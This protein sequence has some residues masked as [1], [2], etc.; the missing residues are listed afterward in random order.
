MKKALNLLLAAAMLLSM[1]ACGGSTEPTQA[2]PTAAATEPAT[3]APTEIPTED[4][5]VAP[6]EPQEPVITAE[7][8]LGLEET[9]TIEGVSHAKY[10]DTLHELGF[11]EVYPDAWGEYE[12]KSL[13]YNH[14]AFKVVFDA[15]YSLMEEDGTITESTDTDWIMYG[16]KADSLMDISGIRYEDYDGVDKGMQVSN[17]YSVPET[18][19]ADVLAP[20]YNMVFAFSVNE[21]LLETS[22][23]ASC[24]SAYY[25]TTQNL[26]NFVRQEE[27]NQNGMIEP[28]A[29]VDIWI[30]HFQKMWKEKGLQ[31]FYP[32]LYECS[33]THCYYVEEQTDLTQYHGYYYEPGMTLADWVQSLYNHEGWV[34]REY[35]TGSAL[36]SPCGAYVMPIMES[37]G[38]VDTI[39]S[40]L[41]G[42]ICEVP[43]FTIENYENEYLANNT[44]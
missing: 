41:F 14:H 7:E 42:R 5:T 11:A 39:E 12:F 27:G 6:T 25:P 4:P 21:A 18:Y 22:K 32:A 35:E 43:A 34:Y 20:Q 16:A 8:L 2:A 17:K 36:I 13:T 29:I 23:W 24:F 3:A 31:T 10:V 1:T 44:Q 30:N 28:P 38:D 37:N 19:Q 33:G 9:Q 40:Y 15:A 26:Y